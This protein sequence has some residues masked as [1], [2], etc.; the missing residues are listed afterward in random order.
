MLFPVSSTV[1]GL[2]ARGVVVR[3]LLSGPLVIARLQARG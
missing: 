3:V 1:F 2:A